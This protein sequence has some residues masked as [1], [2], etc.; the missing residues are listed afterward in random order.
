MNC[1]TSSF[2][3]FP[4]VSW[5]NTLQNLYNIWFAVSESNILTEMLPTDHSERQLKVDDLNEHNICSVILN[6]WCLHSF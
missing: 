6:E 2:T 4:L 3:W 1:I 5:N